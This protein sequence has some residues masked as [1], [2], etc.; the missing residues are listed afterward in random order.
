MAIKLSVNPYNME[1][2]FL[3]VTWPFLSNRTEIFYGNSGDYYI[4][5]MRNHNF[6]AFMKKILFKATGG[7]GRG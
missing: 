2:R 6:D 4:L 3:A 5:A 7:G 1:I